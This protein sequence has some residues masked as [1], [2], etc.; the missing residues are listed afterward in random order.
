MS[1]Q[2]AQGQTGGALTPDLVRAP[3]EVAFRVTIQPSPVGCVWSA[4]ARPVLTPPQPVR[5][6][7]PEAPKAEGHSTHALDALFARGL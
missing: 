6:A 5:P 4:D 7:A 3:G 2:Q 1:A